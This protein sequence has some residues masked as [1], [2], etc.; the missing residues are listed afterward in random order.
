MPDDAR[1]FAPKGVRDPISFADAY[2][3]L[4]VSEQSLEELN[5][6]LEASVGVNRFRPNIVLR[7]SGAFAEDEWRHI[8]IGE[9]PFHF[10]RLCARCNLTTIDPQ[11]A[12]F[13]VEPLRTLAQFRLI[14]QKACFGAYFGPD[15]AG[16]IEVGAPVEIG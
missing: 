2:P 7:G 14:D 9:T 11:T 13:G 1:R 10:C 8:T 12:L 6:R 5:H 4:V 3:A 16:R 15:G